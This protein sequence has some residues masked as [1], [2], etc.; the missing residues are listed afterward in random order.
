MEQQHPISRPVANRHVTA[1]QLTQAE[2]SIA[3][4]MISGFLGSGKTT[5]LRRLLD[6]S[7][8]KRVGVLVN[9]FGQIGIDGRLIEDGDIVLKEI[10][11]GSIFCS[12]LKASFM[13]ALVALSAQPIDLLFIENS[14]IADPTQMPA[15]LENM[16][17]YFKRPIRLCGEIC[18]IDCTSFLDYA[19]VLL[20]IR[21][22]VEAADIALL[23]KIDCATPDLLHAVELQIREWNEHA[24]LVKT[25]YA[26][27]N[28]EAL[29]KLSTHHRSLK[30]SANTIWSRPVSVVL[31]ANG[32]Y[33][34]E[35]ITE[36]L[37]QFGSNL[38]RAKGFARCP[39]GTMFVEWAGGSAEMKPT[40]LSPANCDIQLVTIMKRDTDQ[41]LL[42]ECWNST[43][44]LRS[45]K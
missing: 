12:C 10:N 39:E 27:L 28:M 26:N 36:F 22:Q 5:L 35:I 37:N 44:P 9:E 4:Y 38:Y 33:P 13:E 20:P 45:S 17:P 32:V 14:G 41:E 11:N 16:H 29:P 8:S 40:A 30:K 43:F 19:D 34:R 18:V 6:Q 31:E 21:R 3:L 1:R 42:Q 15:I 24:K 7:S 25:E 23:N 2:D